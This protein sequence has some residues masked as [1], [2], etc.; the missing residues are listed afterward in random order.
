MN[1]YKNYYFIEKTPKIGQ[2]SAKNLGPPKK[3][4][5]KVV[6]RGFRREK[7]V[8]RNFWGGIP[9]REN[10]GFQSETGFFVKKAPRKTVLICE[11]FSGVGKIAIKSGKKFPLKPVK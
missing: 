2:K 3:Y 1:I 10:I 8:F 7:G 4:L 6:S 9:P 11:R 5:K